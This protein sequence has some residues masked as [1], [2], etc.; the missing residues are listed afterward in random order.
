EYYPKD[1]KRQQITHWDPELTA[2]IQH[3][4]YQP[5]VD[6]IISMSERLSLFHSTLSR[7]IPMATFDL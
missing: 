5:V 2:T 4:A 1:K 6:S 3:D 7:T